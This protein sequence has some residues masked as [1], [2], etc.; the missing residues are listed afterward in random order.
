MSIA[1]KIRARRETE[2]RAPYQTVKYFYSSILLATCLLC[3]ALSA[4]ASP[5]A[6]IPAES[7]I[8]FTIKEMGIPV[9]GEFARLEAALDQA[10]MEKS[11]ADQHIDIGSLTTGN[12]EADQV[13]MNPDWLDLS[14]APYATTK[15]AAV[16]PLAPGRLE[17]RG[18]PNIRNKKRDSI[19]QFSS[20]GRPGGKIV[21]NGEIVL[22]RGEFGICAGA[23]NQG[24]IVNDDI[25]VKIF[26][27]LSAYNKQAPPTK[28]A[29]L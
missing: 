24:D 23:W 1:L 4:E 9:S 2:A 5:R 7:R 18:A 25:L 8:T 16:R 6:P 22:R 14:H 29:K 20:T 26:L 19:A 13:T 27:T 21:L 17:S 11:G 12:D 28:T 10:G 15:S 3:A